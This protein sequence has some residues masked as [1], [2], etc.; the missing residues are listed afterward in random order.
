MDKSDQDNFLS[1]T[2]SKAFKKLVDYGGVEGNF[3]L[4]KGRLGQAA[5]PNTQQ[6]LSQIQAKTCRW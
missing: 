1:K 2:K 5:M 6:N 3:I 4:I